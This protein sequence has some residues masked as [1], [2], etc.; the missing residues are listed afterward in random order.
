MKEQ[1]GD[2]DPEHW[3]DDGVLRCVPEGMWQMLLVYRSGGGGVVAWVYG[4]RLFETVE[5]AAAAARAKELPAHDRAHKSGFTPVALRQG[6]TDLSDPDQARFLD[7]VG[8][9]SQAPPLM[10]ERAA[11]G[12][13]HGTGSAR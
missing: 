1:F 7:A 13:G 8:D 4:Q 9:M 2:V 6:A 3:D 12:R 5:G 10:L 11:R